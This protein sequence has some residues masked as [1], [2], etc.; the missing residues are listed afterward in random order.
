[1]LSSHGFLAS[2]VVWGNLPYL[3]IIFILSSFAGLMTYAHFSDCDPVLTQQI[4]NYDEL[5]PYFVMV[6]LGKHRALPGIFASGIF[7]AS[8]R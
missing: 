4:K 8:L 7:A 3:A 6:V 1:M 5:L 2:S